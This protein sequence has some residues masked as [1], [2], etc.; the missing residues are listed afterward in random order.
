MLKSH[1]RFH[2]A[3]G[4]RLVLVADDEFINREILRETL[5][6]EYE[7]VFAEDGEQVIEAMRENRDALSLVLL[8]LMMPVLSGTEA[9]RQAKADPD[10]SQIPIIVITS[11][12]DAEVES[13][14]LGA[15]D[16]IPKPYPRE[17]IIKARILRSIELS[18]DRQIINSTERDVLTGLYNREY[19]YR[20]AEQYDQHHKSVDMDAIVVD[21]NH[22]HMINDRFGTAYGDTVLRRIGEALRETVTD[23]GGIVCR[24]EADTFLIY[25][26]HGKDYLAILEN[27]AAGLADSDDGDSRIWLR[28]GVYANADKTLEIERRFDRAK[29]AADTVQGSFTKRVGIYDS[30]L[31]ERELYSERLVGDFATAIRER[32]FQ[33]HFQPQFDVQVEVPV[34]Q[35]AEALVRWDHPELGMVSPGV[36][37]PLF[38]DNGLIQQLDMYVWRAAAMQVSEWK[39]RYGFVAP[40]SIN[41][42]RI[43]MYDPHLVEE[44]LQIVEDSGLTTDDLVLEITESAYTQAFDQII[45][46]VEELRSLGFKV[47]MDDFGTGYSSLNMISTLPIDALKLDMLFIRNAFGERGDTRMLEI[48]IDIAN[49]LG[50]PT[51]AEGVETEQQ[52]LALREMGCDYV[53]GY[54][55]SR[56]LPAAEYERYVAER[57][58][59]MK[60]ADDAETG[61]ERAKKSMGASA[62]GEI[63]YALAS[64]FEVIYH[65]DTMTSHFVAFSSEGASENLTIVDS[66]ADFFAYLM[67]GPF[68]RLWP[69]DRDRVLAAMRKDA[70]I[71][72]IKDSSPFLMTYRMDVEGEPVHYVLKAVKTITHDVHHIVVGVSCIDEQMKQTGG[73]DRRDEVS[74]AGLAQALSSDME[75]IFF[76][77]VESGNYLEFEADGPYGGP[78]LRKSGENFFDECTRDVLEVVDREDQDRVAEA[79]HKDVLIGALERQGVFSLAYRLVIDGR[80]IHYNLKAV[81]ADREQ[82]HIAI[83]VANVDAQVPEDEKLEE[84]RRSSVTYAGIVQALA[85]D[86]FGIYYVNAETGHFIEYSSRG[87]YGSLGLEK[88]GD[89][90]F[91]TTH[92]NIERIVHPDDA[93]MMPESFTKDNVL[94]TLDRGRPFTLTYRLMLDG[95][96]TYVHLKAT[97]MDGHE[98]RYIVVGVS[99]VDDQI[100]REQEQARALRQARRDALTGVKSMHS[101]AEDERKMNRAISDGLQDRFAVVV[102]DVNGLKRVND[103]KGREMGDRYLRNA[104]AVVC[105][106]FDHSPVYRI[107]GDEFVAVLRG[108]DYRDREQL[109]GQLAASDLAEGADEGVSLAGGL[110]VYR[111]GED[112]AVSAVFARAEAAMYENKNAFG[113]SR[114]TA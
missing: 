61:G 49:Y 36:F 6:D 35:G 71:A 76:V 110:A 23:I 48:V 87:S 67:Q 63:A 26:P 60:G 10:I 40:V 51:I 88:S 38:E 30:A 100:R 66:G 46:T 15:V 90:F 9:L 97:S 68:E 20:Y 77:D 105:S 58:A 95:S 59:Q 69:D 53:Q 24:R 109:M 96:P 33:V 72:Q 108:D 31:R 85:M 113:K 79:L 19:F 17:G 12:Q 62:L 28:M 98:G 55:F 1:E 42:S 65:V 3:N 75:S 13:L 73:V 37:I 106:V 5:Q 2:S 64:G 52:M 92:K 99:D 112:D 57:D 27:A 91:S 93:S 11:D 25:C 101:Y 7:L 22:F 80:P 82:R 111:P 29:M 56:P 44:L 54:Y 70:L 47:E 102:C 45:A 32:Q 74:F 14:T 89:D 114:E 104:C 8:D 103:E 50:V 41:V 86:Y 84:Q 39:Q 4:K 18:E 34:L 16:F 107:G 94:A 43:D 78:D 81:W 21:V 83:G